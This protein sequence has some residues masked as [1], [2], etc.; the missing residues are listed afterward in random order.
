[1]LNQVI[2]DTK[3]KKLQKKNLK[4]LIVGLLILTS[5][6]IILGY[7]SF[8]SQEILRENQIESIKMNDSG[9]VVIMMNL[10]FYRSI[11]SIATAEN[12]DDPD[13]MDVR[14]ATKIDWTLK[15]N[16]VVKVRGFDDLKQVNVDNK[17]GLI[18]KKL[19][20]R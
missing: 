20:V 13:I 5:F 11:D 17:Y 19:K 15:N 2:N 10:P 18:I 1:M 12:I 6:F 8:Y 9:D 7:K 4:F 14:I 16:K 3:I